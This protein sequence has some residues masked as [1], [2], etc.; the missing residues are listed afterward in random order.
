MDLRSALNSLNLGVEVPYCPDCD[1]PMEEDWVR[2]PS[3]Q[4]H[5][6]GIRANVCP[7]CGHAMAIDDGPITP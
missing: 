3:Q 1:V 6:R 5:W 4:S 2:A 7:E